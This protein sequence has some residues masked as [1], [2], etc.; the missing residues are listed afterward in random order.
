MKRP[1]AA[2]IGVSTTGP[3]HLGSVV[4]QDEMADPQTEGEGFRSAGREVL[5]TAYLM[6]SAPPVWED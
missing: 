4:K 5:C 1:G 6:G 2:R 3:D